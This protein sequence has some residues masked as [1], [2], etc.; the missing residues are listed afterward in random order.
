M[1][2]ANGRVVD[3]A[4]SGDGPPAGSP[5]DTPADSPA[6]SLTDGHGTSRLSDLMPGYFC[7][8]ADLHNHTRLSDG[9]G[10]PREAFASMRRAGLGVAAL[11]DHANLASSVGRPGRVP[12]AGWLGGID[13]EAWKQ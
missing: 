10:D 13:R 12:L 4:D 6:I 9:R 7:V 1:R 5:A 3:G 11:T 8:A 2:M